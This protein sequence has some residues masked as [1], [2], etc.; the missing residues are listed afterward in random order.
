MQERDRLARSAL[1]KPLAKSIKKSLTLE[2]QL[3][4]ATGNDDSNH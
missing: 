2:A 1:I 3:S 4:P